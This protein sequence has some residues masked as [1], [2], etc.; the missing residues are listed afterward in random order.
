MSVD[1]E[2]MNY[3]TKHYKGEVDFISAEGPLRSVESE[4]NVATV[5]TE[6]D[7]GTVGRLSIPPE[8][9]PILQEWLEKNGRLKRSLGGKAVEAAN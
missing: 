8:G 6:Y 4:S 1:H 3:S 7:L 2:M 5:G 9:S